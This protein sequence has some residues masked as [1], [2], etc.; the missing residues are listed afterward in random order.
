MKTFFAS[1][2]SLLITIS[3]LAACLRLNAAAIQNGSFEFPLL[4]AGTGVNLPPGS[5]SLIGWVISGSG[6]VGLGNGSTAVSAVSPV[7][8]SQ[9]V[10]FNSG[11]Y[12]H[13]ASISRT[14]ASV[15]GNSYRG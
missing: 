11:D 1:R 7:D 13:G 4:P 10:A 15:P 8:G 6:L 5:D 9:H 12:A 3:T 14:F 2:V